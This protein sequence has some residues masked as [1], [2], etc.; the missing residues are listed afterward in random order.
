MIK[1]KMYRYLGRNGTITTP[2]K[3]ENVDPIPMIRLKASEGKVLTNGI[4]TTLSVLIF[5]DDL[6][7]WKEIDK[8]GQD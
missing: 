8:E 4:N 1:E 2:I 5:E 6:L 7:N 3:I